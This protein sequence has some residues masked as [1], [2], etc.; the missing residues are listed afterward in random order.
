MIRIGIIGGSGLYELEGLQNLQQH[1]VQTPFGDPSDT[2]VAGT[3]HGREVVF[4]PRHGKGHR[5][6]PTEVPI[7]ANVWALKKLGVTH[8]ISVSAVGSLKEE[9]APGHLVFPDQFIDRTMHRDATFFG[10][11][12]VGHVQFGNPVCAHLAADLASSARRLAIPFHS[13]GTYVCI[14]GPAFSTKAESNLYRSWGGAVIGMTNMQEA[15]LAREAEMCFATIALATD[16]DCWHE[17]EAEV[18]V[19]AVLQVMR[20][21]V[22]AS[23][24]L[25]AA[26]VASMG[27]E[28]PCGAADA[29]KFAIVTPME[30][31][32][33]QT[34]RDLE[35][36]IG[37]YLPHPA[38]RHAR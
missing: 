12:M 21:N 38:D 14:E 33:E 17:T 13:G 1:A 23:K 24:R 28:R 25:L 32:P 2:L 18:S 29:L 37:R 3:L 8:L 7:K 31:V 35:P 22:E 19:E 11:G 6:L 20:Q 26:T 4:L 27:T 9:I 16:Y 15:K 5:L 30:Q 10:R 34:K 36:L